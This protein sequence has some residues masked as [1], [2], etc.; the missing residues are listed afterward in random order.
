MAPGR[1][2][3]NNKMKAQRHQETLQRYADKYKRALNCISRSHRVWTETVNNCV[4][5]RGVSQPLFPSS[6]RAAIAASEDE[7]KWAYRA[8]SLKSAAKYH[9]QFMLRTPCGTPVSPRTY[10]EKQGL[11]A[12]DEKTSRMHMSKT[13]R[14]HEGRPPARRPATLPKKLSRHA[15]LQLEPRDYPANTSG[16]RH[17][18]R[19]PPTLQQQRLPQTPPPREDRPVAAETPVFFRKRRVRTPPPPQTPPPNN[20]RMR[21]RRTPSEDGDE[22]NDGQ[23]A[24]DAPAFFP[25]RISRQDRPAACGVCGI[26]GCCG[27]KCVCWE[28]TKWLD[29]EHY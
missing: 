2:P 15:L 11:E 22:S 14:T 9:E 16:Q 18:E 21:R 12:F 17:N 28:S 20:K 23:L 13:Q 7:V 8:K 24:A 10:I 29:H 6:R 25:G 19:P 5:L 4:L 3:L 27:C 1:K 26:E